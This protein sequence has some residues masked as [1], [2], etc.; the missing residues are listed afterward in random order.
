[1]HEL[2]ICQALLARVEEIA[3]QH[4]ASSVRRVRVSVGPL[5]GVDPALLAR[6][7]GFASFGTVAEGSDLAI[8]VAPVRVRCRACGAESAARANR[9][10]CAECGSWQADVASGDELLMLDVELSTELKTVPLM[11]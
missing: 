5:S 1:M 3:C 8:E 11:I 10:L 2:S 4:A 9:L 7:Y 6:A